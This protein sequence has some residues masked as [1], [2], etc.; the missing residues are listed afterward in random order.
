M[1]R[2]MR[3]SIAA[4]TV[5]AA[6]LVFAAGAGAAAWQPA[7]PVN[8]ST[9]SLPSVAIDGVGNTVVTWQTNPVSP[10]PKV[11]Q[12]SRHVFGGVGFQQLPDVASDATTNSDAIA[13]VNRAGQGFVA[14]AHDTGLA[15]NQ[16]VE[17]RA[18]SPGGILGA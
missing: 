15:N 18:V 9:A 4:A 14:W 6:V 7:T 17:M 5:L 11:L 10:A 16:Q 8:L 3:L 13:V 12:A 1:L 2:T